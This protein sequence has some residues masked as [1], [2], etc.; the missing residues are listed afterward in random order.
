MSLGASYTLRCCSLISLPHHAL[1][2]LELLDGSRRLRD[3]QAD[4]VRLAGGELVPLENLA[5]LDV[6]DGDFL[7][8]EARKRLPKPRTEESRQLFPKRSGSPSLANQ[9]KASRRHGA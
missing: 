8:A 7:A 4:V 6:E 5:K 9:G 2:L 3:L 1:P